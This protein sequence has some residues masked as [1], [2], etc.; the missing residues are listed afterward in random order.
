MAITVANVV[1]NAL[2][3]YPDLSQAD[4]VAYLNY[5]WRDLCAS[6]RLE[7]ETLVSV[8][9][10]EGTAKY[11]LDADAL[12]VW[13]AYWKTASNTYI[14]LKGHTI[15]DIGT[16]N[17]KYRV[18]ANGTPTGYYIEGGYIALTPPPRT[19][20][21]GSYPVLV[22]FATIPTTW[23]YGYTALP[24]IPCEDALVAGICY[25]HARA[26]HQNEHDFWFGAYQGYKTLLAR[27][28]AGISSNIQAEGSMFT[29]GGDTPIGVV[30]R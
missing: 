22:Y 12:R 6:I 7:Q 20:T 8:N 26:Y 30:N 25:R 9:V 13:E 10:T 28:V 29:P 4:A 2:R 17:S 1:D 21:S 5:A 14:V 15:A 19:S 23:S 24:V 11:A 18:E 27:H 16:S 3:V